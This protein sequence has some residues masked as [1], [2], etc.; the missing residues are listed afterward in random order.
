MAAL[1]LEALLARALASQGDPIGARFAAARAFGPQAT[2]PGWV[3]QLE[4]LTAGRLSKGRGDTE[5]AFD[6]FWLAVRL[7]MASTESDLDLL[8]ETF[9]E[10]AMLGYVS[11]RHPDPAEWA[12]V[13]AVM[14]R[15]RPD[16]EWQPSSWYE[17]QFR[18]AIEWIQRAGSGRRMNG[19]RESP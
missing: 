2:P 15:D 3:M 12:E 11:P 18:A 8:L 10:L 13:I 19:I 9:C 4:A 5:A 16:D 17:G 6:S 14:T 7:W 1:Q